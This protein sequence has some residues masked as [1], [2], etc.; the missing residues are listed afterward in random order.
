[1][2]QAFQM[3]QLPSYFS[4]V[5]GES[6]IPYSLFCRFST[7]RLGQAVLLQQRIDLIRAP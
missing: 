5:F 3:L 6:S 7:L 2:V 1:M 4:L